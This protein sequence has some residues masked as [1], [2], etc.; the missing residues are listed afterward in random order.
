[1]QILPISVPQLSTQARIFYSTVIILL[2]WLAGLHCYLFRNDD[3][4]STALAETKRDGNSSNSSR[5]GEERVP[6]H[7]VYNVSKNYEPPLTPGA[8]VHV[9]KVSD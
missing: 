8:F 7:Q 3:A 6:D 4:T 9:G 2:V 5:Y 1:M